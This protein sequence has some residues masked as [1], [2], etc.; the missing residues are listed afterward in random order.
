MATRD[1]P[2]D[3][4][5]RKY[6]L[7]R[8]A[9]KLSSP[10][11]AYA[12]AA[13]QRPGAPVSPVRNSGPQT[14]R[15]TC[16]RWRAARAGRKPRRARGRGRWGSAFFSRNY[17]AEKAAGG[18]KQVGLERRARGASP[19]SLEFGNAASSGAPPLARIPPAGRGSCRGSSEG[20]AAAASR[21][22][23][24]VDQLVGRS[25]VRELRSRKISAGT[26]LPGHT[27]RVLACVKLRPG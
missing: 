22:R 24:R 4:S 7:V 5:A 2:G 23:M 18:P 16:R 20:K 11:G 21:C 1:Y 6:I 13:E 15:S 10:S 14:R 27:I 9:R 26:P 25:F 17:A 12:I 8:R 19:G 3:K